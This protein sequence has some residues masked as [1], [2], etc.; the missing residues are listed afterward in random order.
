MDSTETTENACANTQPMSEWI[1][2]DQNDRQCRSCLLGPVVQWYSD[3][4]KENDKE[5]EAAR[6]EGLAEKPELTPEELCST[7]DAIKEKAT[8]ELRSRLLDFD[9][10]AQ[11]YQD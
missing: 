7:L 3:T 6:L 1:K 11:T 10:A 8:A 5:E 4:L 9:C 2:G